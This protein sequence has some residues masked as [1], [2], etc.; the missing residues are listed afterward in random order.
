MKK[1]GLQPRDLFVSVDVM[2]F[3]TNI[4][5]KETLKIIKNK[6]K[7]T[8]YG[9]DLTRFVRRTQLSQQ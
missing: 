7:P 5:I 6:Y 9:M 8:E 4:P 1:E 2:S 3:V